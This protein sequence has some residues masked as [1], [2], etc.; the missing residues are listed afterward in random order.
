VLY[1]LAVKV[2]MWANELPSFWPMTIGCLV[3]GLVTTLIHELGHGI[4]GALVT[5]D[6]VK[7]E[8]NLVGG[9]CRLG[10]HS[11]VTLGSYMLIVAAGPAA[12]FLQGLVSAWLLDMT[13]RG[14]FEHGFLAIMTFLGFAAA[15]LNLIPMKVDDLHTDGKQLLDLTRWAVSGRIPSWARS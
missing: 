9:L 11:R 12:S 3:L 6:R 15:I 7:I 5:K 1:D 10:E 14:T 8:I 4:V 2:T 13:A